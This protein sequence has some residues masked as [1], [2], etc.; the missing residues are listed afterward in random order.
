MKEHEIKKGRAYTDGQNWETVRLVL[1]FVYCP[2]A[3]EEE[4]CV[5]YRVVKGSVSQ[6]G[7]EN[8]IT[9]KQFA[10]QACGCV[11]GY[12]LPYIEGE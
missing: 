6:A 11:E 1:K 8:T 2:A 10:H 4:M 7:T 12:E 9:L 5:R 3:W